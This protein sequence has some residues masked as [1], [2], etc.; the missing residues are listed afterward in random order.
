[1][2]CVRAGPQTKGQ[3]PYNQAINAYD[4]RGS[5]RALDAPT[6]HERLAGGK[7]DERVG[8]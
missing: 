2:S 4:L 7:V 8:A 6:D 3:R 1:M 5:Q